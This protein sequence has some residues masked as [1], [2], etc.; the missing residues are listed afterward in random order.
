MY[1]SISKIVETN[2]GV[3]LNPLSWCFRSVSEPVSAMITKYQQCSFRVDLECP[4][5]GGE[6]SESEETLQT[7]ATTRSY[8]QQHHIH[9]PFSL[10]F[11]ITF[12]TCSQSGQDSDLRGFFNQIQENIEVTYV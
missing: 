10:Y 12:I 3:G 7:N 2:Y 4:Q 9:N 11:I 8:F 1:G 6:G 5:T